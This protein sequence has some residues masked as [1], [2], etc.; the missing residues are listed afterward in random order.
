V[1]HWPLD[2]VKCFKFWSINGTACANCIRTCPFNKP[3]GILH[4]AVRF[5]VKH[6]RRLNPLI[7]KADDIMGYGKQVKAEAFW[8]S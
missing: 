4:K 2:A 3:S 8:K 5:G 1:Y 7:L 6:F